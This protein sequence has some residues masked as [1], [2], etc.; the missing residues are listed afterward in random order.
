MFRE[1]LENR[2][3][4]SATASKYTSILVDGG[5]T[6]FRDVVSKTDLPEVLR[7]YSRCI[8]TTFYIATAL[9]TL[10]LIAC[11]GM[12]GVRVRK[13]NE[14]APDEMKDS[15]KLD[16]TGWV[17]MP[18]EDWHADFWSPGAVPGVLPKAEGLRGVYTGTGRTRI[19][20]IRWSRRSPLHR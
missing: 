10:T 7:I 13:P 17:A 2:T 20:G 5:A 16:Q 18:E 1:V 11:L 15:S 19:R 4:G 3:E 14:L 9:G 8:S 12:R 6:E